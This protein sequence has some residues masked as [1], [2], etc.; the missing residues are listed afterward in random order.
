M[1][2]FFKMRATDMTVGQT[3]LY[4]VLVY[5]I[6]FAAVIVACMMPQACEEIMDWVEEKADKIKEKLKK[7]PDPE[8]A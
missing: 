5:V 3:L 7:K 2:N 4:I 6:A 8:M 1:K